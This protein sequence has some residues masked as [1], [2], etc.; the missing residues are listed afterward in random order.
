[1]SIKNEYREITEGVEIE[2]HCRFEPEMSKAEALKFVFS[3]Q[4]T[5]TNYGA[6][7]VKLLRRKWNIFD[8]A[9]GHRE[10]E[11]EGVVGVQPKIAP[12]CQYT[13]S[14]WCPLEG[15]IGCMSGYYEM[16]KLGDGQPLKVKIPRVNLMAWAL[17]N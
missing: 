14:S 8:A 2:V 1:M 9:N 13:Y 7:T 15:P 11:G 12:N 5:I 10:V 16:V 3:Y 17:L 4:I 6:Q